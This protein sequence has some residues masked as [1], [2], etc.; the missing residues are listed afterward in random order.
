MPKNYQ[1]KLQIIGG[2][3]AD[4]AARTVEGWASRYGELDAAGDIVAPGAFTKSLQEHGDDPIPF[5]WQH[6]RDMPIGT[7][8]AQDR[9][10]GLWVKAKFDDTMQ[11][12]EAYKS[13]KSRAVKGF[14]IGYDALETEPDG[15]VKMKNGAPAKR[16]KA[17]KL[18]EVSLVTFPALESARIMSIKSAFGDEWV[19]SMATKAIPSEVTVGDFVSWGDGDA[20]SIGKIQYIYD[21]PAD[22]LPPDA[23]PTPDAPWI[24][25]QVYVTA[26]DGTMTPAETSV[27]LPLLDVDALGKSVQGPASGPGDTDVT[28]ASTAAAEEPEA[29]V[30]MEDP[31]VV[32]DSIL[33][34][35]DGLAGDFRA[36]RKIL[37]NAAG[38]DE[39]SEENEVEAEAESTASGADAPGLGA[40]PYITGASAPSH[41]RKARAFGVVKGFM[42]SVKSARESAILS[43]GFRRIAD[44]LQ[45]TTK[46]A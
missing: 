35:M 3:K 41:T 16:L 13:V 38:E 5:L 19:T 17:I 2:F 29:P 20:P 36:F 42:G 46:R 34:H 37:A 39:E 28:P 15:T 11:A 44:L 43:D 18:Y 23:V 12:N 7:L 30:N 25:V 27:D 21:G 6:K 8:E 40:P 45:T 31:L 1:H 10:E 4:D 9:A 26:P 33:S 32:L 22:N 14:S 24:T